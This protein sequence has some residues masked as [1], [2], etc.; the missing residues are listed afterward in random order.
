MVED[1]VGVCLSWQKNLGTA[2]TPENTAGLGL[3]G[4]IALSIVRLAISRHF[5]QS[6]HFTDLDLVTHMTWIISAPL[7]ADIGTAGKK[8]S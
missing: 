5:R 1:R 8:A 7:V 3:I 6:S 4:G 2:Y